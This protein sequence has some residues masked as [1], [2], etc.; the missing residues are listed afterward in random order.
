M[1]SKLAKNCVT[2]GTFQKTA[3]KK[4]AFVCRHILETANYGTLVK[5]PHGVAVAVLFGVCRLSAAYSFILLGIQPTLLCR[6]Y[7]FSRAQIRLSFLLASV[8]PALL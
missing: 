2:I 5:I 3:Y 7:L 1:M 6:L 4:T 8:F